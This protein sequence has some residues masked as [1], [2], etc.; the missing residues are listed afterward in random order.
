[1]IQAQT[2]RQEWF[3]NVRN[4]LLSGTVV[5]LALIPEAIAFSIVAGVDPKIGLYA[6]FVIAV[7]T[8]ILGGR[9]AMISAATGAMA[10]LMV[11]LVKDHGIQYLFAAGVLAG[12]IQVA[13]GVMKLG[14]LMRFVPKPVMTGFVNALA[15]LIFM[16]QLPQ[17]QGAGP[18]MYIML[19]CSLIII[20]GLPRLTKAVPAPLVAIVLM[21]IVSIV[22]K[23]DVRRVGDMGA[24]PSA[25]PMFGIPNVP[26][27]TET[28]KI[29]LP[30]S[31]SLALVG[32]VESLLTAS[33]VDDLTDTPSDKNR[34]MKGQGIANVVSSFFGGMAGCAM[35]GQTVINVK[36]GGRGRLST[37]ASGVLLL[38]FILVLGKWV[39]QIPMAALVAVM[40]MVS[41]GTFE[42]ASLRDLR[43][44][45]VGESIVMAATVV[46]VIQTHDLAKGVLVG[47]L[48]SAILFVRKLAHLIDV[49]SEREDRVTT[50]HVHGALFFVSVGGFLECLDFQEEVDLVV[51]DL[52]H[53]HVWDHSAVAAIDKVV[54]RFRK[55]GIEVEVQG[56]NEA[57][58]GIVGRLAMFDKDG[59]IESG[60]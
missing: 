36:S 49:T 43:T 56:M 22:L 32:L 21:T 9:P 58:A 12:I 8:A 57:S 27:T 46:T 25:L 18:A 30:Y 17:F 51:L 7:I 20:Y 29:I 50:Y 15:I 6:S 40:F 14:S 34:E 33:L 16:A 28:L 48:L 39:T 3:G 13:L 4:D 60:H 24:L 1:M 54:A 47:V 38:F 45:P 19:V 37:F 35:I 11:T 26:F 10:L 42:W 23:L 41:F 55:R 5:A 44:L 2:V 53:S 59:P 31:I 52:T